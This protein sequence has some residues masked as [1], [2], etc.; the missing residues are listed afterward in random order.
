MKKSLLVLAL[1]AAGA[2]AEDTITIA[3]AGPETGP[4][5]Q[6]GTIQKIGAE[7][8]IDFVNANGG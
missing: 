3:L 4:V 1:F 5:T 6:Y 2:H 8:A 7:A